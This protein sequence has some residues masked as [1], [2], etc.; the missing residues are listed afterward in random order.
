MEFFFCTCTNPSIICNLAVT[1][2]KIVANTD[3]YVVQGLSTVIAVE[4][5]IR[6][7]ALVQSVFQTAVQSAL[8][9]NAIVPILGSSNVIVVD[10][11]ALT[12]SLE[13]AP[14]INLQPQAPAA[15]AAPIPTPITAPSPTVQ[16][17][18]AIPVAV[19]VPINDVAP[20]GLTFAPYPDILD[21]PSIDIPTTIITTAPFQNTTTPTMI[22]TPISVSN[23]TRIPVTT[24]APISSNDGINREQESADK[25][26]LKWWAWL[27]IVLGGLFL[28]LCGYGA[29]LNHRDETTGGEQRGAGTSSNSLKKASMKRKSSKS[30]TRK[31]GKANVPPETEDDDDDA[32]VVPYEPP[33]G[34]DEYI[35]PPTM[36]ITNSNSNNKSSTD[37]SNKRDEYVVPSIP[38]IP[39]FA[40]PSSNVSTPQ[41]PL[42]VPAFVNNDLNANFANQEGEDE[43]DDDE[44]EEEDEDEDD[45]EVEYERDGY[46]DEEGEYTDDEDEELEEDEQGEYNQHYHQNHEN[47][48]V[49]EDEESYYEEE[50]DEDGELDTYGDDTNPMSHQGS[51]NNDW[52]DQGPPSFGGLY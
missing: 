33:N 12:D 7:D 20:Q 43:Y 44:D 16:L 42:L 51:G 28:A 50:G 31:K 9:N 3:C 2:P 27:L 18:I 26:G 40:D 23:R 15:V 22:P 4:T 17:P 29:W 34:M 6:N 8:Q 1:C 13:V 52:A 47:G 49:F 11:S 14:P 30:L 36:T 45:E 25:D 38:P 35:P 37:A 21:L 5:G 48:E 46:R 41:S 39:F 19:P 32:N 24:N 10:V